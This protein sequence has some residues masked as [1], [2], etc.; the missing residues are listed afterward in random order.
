M[1][2]GESIKIEDSYFSKTPFGYIDITRKFI[3]EIQM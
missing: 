2:K 3:L 1:I